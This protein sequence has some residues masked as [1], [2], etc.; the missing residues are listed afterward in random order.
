MSIF[1]K[2]EFTYNLLIVLIAFLGYAFI[3]FL[4]DYLIIKKHDN[5]GLSE[6][7]KLLLQ[8]IVATIFFGLFL[9]EGNEPLIWIHSLNIKFNTNISIYFMLSTSFIFSMDFTYSSIWNYIYTSRSHS[10]QV[11]IIFFF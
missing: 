8:V 3:G 2:I 9:L 10:I 6:N 1:D 7:Q 11:F 5:K 4:D